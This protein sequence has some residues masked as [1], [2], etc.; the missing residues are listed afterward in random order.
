MERTCKRWKPEREYLKRDSDDQCA[1]R[2]R[3][4]QRAPRRRDRCIAAHVT[5][6]QQLAERERHPR[7]RRRMFAVLHISR[8]PTS[9]PRATRP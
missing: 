9:M 8:S 5:E 6:L 2:V 4:S 3:I 7:D 1:Q